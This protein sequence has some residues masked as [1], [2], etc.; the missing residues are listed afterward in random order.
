MVA[1][2]TAPF[3]LGH[4]TWWL[5]QGVWL[6]LTAVDRSFWPVMAG[7]SLV[8]GGT[9]P[10][11]FMFQSWEVLQLSQVVGN[12]QG[13]GFGTLLVWK[14][15]HFSQVVGGN[16]KFGIHAFGSCS[17]FW[18]KVWLSN[19][20]C[21]D[22]N[23]LFF[24]D[25]YCLLLLVPTFITVGLGD[26]SFRIFCPMSYFFFLSLC[27]KTIINTVSVHGLYF[28]RQEIKHCKKKDILYAFISERVTW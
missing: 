19:E 27:T 3:C 23:S 28:W 13:V 4:P 24:L 1:K 16:H 7:W 18:S 12:L 10:L 22:L 25:C 17:S 6:E 2:D 9:A 14:V 5:N 11:F 26:K 21:L 15:F 20:K 8:L